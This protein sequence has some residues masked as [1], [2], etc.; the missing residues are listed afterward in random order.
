M[1]YIK[2]FDKDADYQSLITSGGGGVV[3]PNVSHTVD[4]NKVYYNPYDPS[5]EPTTIIEYT[6][7]DGKL[8]N[9]GTIYD[10]GGNDTGEKAYFYGNYS[11]DDHDNVVYSNP[12]LIK[13]NTYENGIGKLIIAGNA[14]VIGD[15]YFRGR[16]TL[17]TITITDPIE[18]LGSIL[19]DDSTSI[20]SITLKTSKTLMPYYKTKFELFG[21][22]LER[23]TI[24][25]PSS[26]KSNY[27]HY[28][29]WESIKSM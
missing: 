29:G 12:L 3:L 19:F 4:A 11:Y 7:T 23:L 8:I 10:T 9:F 15:C 22:N 26:L 21:G 14:K 6:T 1:K 20:E 2:L 13:S 28:W 18:Y 27:D 25:V 17:K 16:R 5:A 24:Y